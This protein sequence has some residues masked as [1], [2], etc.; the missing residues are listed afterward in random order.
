MHMHMHIYMY[1]Y[2][3]VYAIRAISYVY[4]LSSHAAI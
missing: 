2:M 4:M 3:S 1:M